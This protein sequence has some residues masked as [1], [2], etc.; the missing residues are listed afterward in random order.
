MSVF[1]DHLLGRQTRN[2][3]VIRRVSGY[4]V[5]QERDKIFLVTITSKFDSMHSKD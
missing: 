5:S 1:V 2:L 3:K 4:P